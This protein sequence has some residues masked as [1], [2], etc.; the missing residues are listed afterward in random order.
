MKGNIAQKVRDIFQQF[1]IEPKDIFLSEEV[2]L[3]IQNTLQDGTVIYTSATEWGVGS[4][5][6]TKDESGTAVPLMAGEYV[7]ADGRTIVIGED[8]KIAEIK[9]VMVEEDMSTADLLKTIESLSARV[10][11]LEGEKTELLNKLSKAEAAN[12]TKSTELSAVTSELAEIK[13]SAAADS[14]KDKRAEVSLARNKS[15]KQPKS[16]SQMSIRERV[17]FNLQNN[18]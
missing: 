2:K 12:I 18:K 17:E 7:L 6:Y 3:E 11:A 8:T 16:F 9:E 5:V 13:K 4:D 14:V 10:S 15:M 1:K